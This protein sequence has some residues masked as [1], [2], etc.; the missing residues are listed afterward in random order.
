[1]PTGDYLIVAKTLVLSFFRKL[2]CV[3]DGG[4]VFCTIFA[5]MTLASL[6]LCSVCIVLVEQLVMA[7]L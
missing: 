2:S 3:S 6:Y 5:R 4:K 7:S 1:M